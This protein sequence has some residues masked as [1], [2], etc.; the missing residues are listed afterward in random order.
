MTHGRVNKP[1]LIR[2]LRVRDGFA[3]GNIRILVCL[4]ELG[5]R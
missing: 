3:L 2:G 1:W 5:E 4:Q